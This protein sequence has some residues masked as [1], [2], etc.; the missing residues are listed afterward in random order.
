[1]KK[2]N[3]L[4]VSGLLAGLV[5]T[6]PSFSQDHNMQKGAVI[7]AIGGALAGQAIG[8]NTTGTLIGAGAGALVGA[9]TGN[10]V[11]QST[12]GRG[13]TQVASAPPVVAA[14]PP[15]R[16]DEAP[17][18]EWVEIPGQWVNG[19]WVPAHRAWVPVNPE[20]PP[21]PPPVATIPEPAPPAYAFPAP[22]EVALIPGTYA[23]FVPGIG[24]DIFFYHGYWYRPFGGRWYVAQYYKGPWAFVTA[25]RVPGVLFSLPPGWRRVPPGYRPIP[26]RDLNRNWERWERERHWDRRGH[27]DRH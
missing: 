21:P 2:R 3:L 10:A 20:G 4:V 27:W 24:I 23:Y 15:P 1:M 9:I 13:Q 25:S 11:D 26:H 5:W 14:P 18:G 7:G 6:Q 12:A 8:R 16:G 22:P 17:P 19:R